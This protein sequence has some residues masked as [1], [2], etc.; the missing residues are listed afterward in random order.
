ME[1]P[2]YSD[3]GVYMLRKLLRDAVRGNT[4]ADSTRPIAA[5]GKDTLHVY[6][7]DTVINAPKTSDG[8]DG[9]LMMSYGLKILEIMKEAND[10]P[11]AERDPYIRARIDELDGGLQ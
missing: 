10:M 9:E 2:G 1:N 7:Q 5:G 3:T 11:G 4:P 6:T 8:D